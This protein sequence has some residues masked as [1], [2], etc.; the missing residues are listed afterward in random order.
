MAAQA[1][2]TVFDGAATPATHTL[3]GEE[4]RRDAGNTSVAVWREQISS[5]PMY[6]QITATQIKRKLK[7]GVNQIVSRVEVPVME[8]IAGPNS[9]GYTAQPKVAFTERF[10]IVRFA[11][12]RSTEASARLAMQILLNWANNVT[13]S[14]TAVSTGVVADAHQ[15][16]QQPT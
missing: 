14:V 6:A 10:E 11:H 12:E 16:L 15:R 13:T 1:T 4:V 3:V 2:I 9:F 7:S 8:A 5:V